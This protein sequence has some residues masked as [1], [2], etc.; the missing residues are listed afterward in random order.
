MLVN[1]MAR[2]I[3]QGPEGGAKSPQVEQL[4]RSEIGKEANVAG[5]E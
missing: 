2:V 4:E 3:K 5:G 1:R